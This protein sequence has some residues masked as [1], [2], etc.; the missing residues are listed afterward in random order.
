MDLLD[1]ILVLVMTPSVVLVIVYI[2]L[3]GGLFVELSERK[4]LEQ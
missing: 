4:R 1:L 2:V 3:A